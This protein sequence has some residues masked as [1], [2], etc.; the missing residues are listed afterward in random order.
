MLKLLNLLRIPLSRREGF[1]LLSLLLP[2]FV[3]DL[4]LKAAG[5]LPEHADYGLLGVLTS[6]W[7]DIFFDLG[8]AVFCVA[9]YAAVPKGFLSWA[10]VVLF[11]ATTILILIVNACAYQY[12]EVT[13]TMLDYLTFA[14]W[15]PKFEEIRP[16]LFQEEGS[17]SVWL[18]LSV[19]LF[20]ATFGPL[21]LTDAV[22]QWRGWPREPSPYEMAEFNLWSLLG[23]FLL[24][25]GFGL[26]SLLVGSRPAGDVSFAADPFLNLAMTGVKETA[27]GGDAPD[28]S[29][30]S[31]PPPADASLSETSQVQKRNVVLIH[32]ESTREESVTPYNE[33]L[34]TTP[35]LDELAK[36]SLLAERAYVVL[37]RSSKGSV[38][39]NCGIEP[40]LY[41][42]PEFVLGYIPAPCLASL[43]K[44]QGYRTVFFQSNIN[45]IDNFGDI[46]KNMGY[47]EFY[48]TESMDTEGFQVT[49]TFGYEDDIMLGPSE[50]WLKKHGD[51][52]FMAEYLT[53]TG[54]YGYQCVPNRYGTENFS[55]DDQL[56]RYLNCLHYLDNFVENLMDQYKELGLYDNTIFVLFGD[57]GEGF[58]EHDRFMHGD[59]P[60]E[61]GLRI[62]LMIH[63][64]GRFGNGERVQGLSSQIDIL[65]TVLD[66]LGYEVKGG[67]YSGFSLLHELPE[68]RTLS[69]S[70]IS[71][72]ECLASIKG[73][74]KYIYHYG[75]QPDEVFNLSKDPLETRNL[76]NLFSK[77]A[78]DKRREDLLRWHSQV[79]AGYGDILMNGTLLYPGESP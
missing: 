73:Y 29:P 10:L 67:E 30:V 6:I 54:H 44:G 12:F 26:L 41:P 79:N 28:A 61:E 34:Q 14:E 36:S 21:L 24:A 63:A 48:P 64:P 42:G 47:E 33:N 57:H 1:Y 66:L 7:S 60:Y 4:A 51:E 31:K 8:C 27:T 55:E 2:F 43:L 35:F 32:L 62:P 38:S 68:D 23:L 3:Y 16:I 40:A 19:A 25:L 56:N 53:S 11:H 59:T 78:L 49:N 37:P 52:P 76:A 9:F 70:C 77:E 46:V 71:N 58:G 72:R 18:I 45:A 5:V 20:Y 50:E 15:I 22:E 65:P 13:G 74:Q 39:V 69:F 75:K 17:L